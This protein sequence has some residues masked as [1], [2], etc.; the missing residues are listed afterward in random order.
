MHAGE[1]ESAIHRLQRGRHILEQQRTRIALMDGAGSASP[2]SKRLL[3]QMEQ[4]VAEF[5]HE[6][7]LLQAEKAEQASSRRQH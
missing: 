4:A 6:V 7:E 2:Q 3:K 5:E 1:I